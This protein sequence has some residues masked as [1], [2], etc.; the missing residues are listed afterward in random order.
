MTGSVAGDQ[1]APTTLHTCAEEEPRS[2]DDDRVG[3]LAPSPT[4]PLHLGHAYA[5]LHAWWWT[6]SRGGRMRLRWDDGD[7]TR[8]RPEFEDQALADLEWLG[9]TW[10]GPVV[11]QSDCGDAHEAAL[12]ELSKLG[13]LFGCQCT[14]KDLAAQAAPHEGEEVSY[15]GTCSALGLPGPALRMRVPGSPVEVEEHC[16]RLQDGAAVTRIDLS[17][18][19]GPFLVASRTGIPSYHLVTAVDDAAMG[20]TDVA[21]GRDLLTSLGRQQLIRQRLG[22]GS[23]AAAHL[24]LVVDASGR[25]LAKRS[26]D[27]ALSSLREAGVAPRAVLAW[28]LTDGPGPDC[29]FVGTSMSEAHRQVVAKYRLPAGRSRTAPSIDALLESS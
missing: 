12:R 26:R 16:A 10:D 8:C 22:L 27:L 21:R 18:E 11:R 17:A 1:R 23:V 15:P 14:R 24:P 25:R 2:G 4:G 9:L 13:V 28:A 7:R 5:F 19:G 6:R 3:R 20:V 29:D